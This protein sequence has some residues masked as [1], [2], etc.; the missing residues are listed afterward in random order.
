[1]GVKYF[2]FIERFNFIQVN[3]QFVIIYNPLSTKATIIFVKE[4]DRIVVATIINHS[5]P[6]ENISEELPKLT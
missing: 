2:S 5:L 3:L 1:M 6:M 4:Y